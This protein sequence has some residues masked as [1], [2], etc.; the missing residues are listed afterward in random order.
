LAPLNPPSCL[1]VQQNMPT[2][3]LTCP[4]TSLHIGCN[5]TPHRLQTVVGWLIVTNLFQPSMAAPRLSQDSVVPVLKA[6]QKPVAVPALKRLSNRPINV[7]KLWLL[8]LVDRATQ[9]PVAATFSPCLG[10]YNPPRSAIAFPLLAKPPKDL[11][12]PLLYTPSLKL[13]Y[14]TLLFQAYLPKAT[15]SVELRPNSTLSMAG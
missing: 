9:G 15:R 12:Q 4:C 6:A 2:G 11:F 14:S 10:C 7:H 13:P 5:K 3:L 1:I 8:L